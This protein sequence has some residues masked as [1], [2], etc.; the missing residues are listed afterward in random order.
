MSTTIDNRV[1]SLEFDS[2]GFT[3]KIDAAQKKLEQFEETLEFK[4]VEKSGNIFTKL[5][6]TINKGAKD[7]DLSPI[8]KELEKTSSSFNALETIVTG[9]FLKLGAQIEEVGMKLA[10]SL[11]VDQLSTGWSKYEQILTA[12]QTLVAALGESSFDEIN[13]T[14]EKLTWY[15]DETSYNLA[16]MVTNISKFANYGIDLEDSANAM[17][18]I[19]N[20]TAKAGGN[21]NNASH[22]MQGFTKAISMGLMQY[23]T[24]RNWIEN[25]TIA[26]MDFKQQM[27]ETAY[28]MGELQKDAA[29]YYFMY[30]I[31]GGQARYDVTASNMGSSDSLTK[32]KWLTSDVMLE[33][34]AKY[35]AAVNDIYEITKE[36]GLA[37]AEVFDLV[38]KG[39][40]TLDEYSMSA[41]K[42]AQQAKTFS[43][44]IDAL[45]DALSTKWYQIF[46]LMF[47]NYKQSVSLWSEF[48]EYLYEWFVE[49]V[50]AVVDVITEW[51]ETTTKYGVTARDLFVNAIVN[52]ADA[53][54]SIIEPIKNAWAI[55]FNPVTSGDLAEMTEGFYDFTSGLVLTKNQAAKF[56]DVM[57]TVFSVI[58]TVKVVIEAIAKA[59]AKVLYPI[60]K[61][62]VTFIGKIIYKVAK[63]IYKG[64]S[65]LSSFLSI[66]FGLPDFAAEFGDKLLELAEDLDDI[67]IS[68]SSATK[69]IKKTADAA[70]STASSTSA[71]TT[72][73]NELSNAT[74]AETTTS[75]ASANSTSST[76]NSSS[77]T[78]EEDLT[79]YDSD[80]SYVKM[81]KQVKQYKK[82]VTDAK[83]KVQDIKDAVQKAKNEFRGITE[84]TEAATESA[85][86]AT[87]TV[88]DATTA[89]TDATTAVTNATTAVADAQSTVKTTAEEVSKTTETVK[90]A[91][92]AVTTLKDTVD[93]ASK[94]T[95]EEA[96]KATEATETTTE[97]IKEEERQLKHLSLAQLGKN[98]IAAP[99]LIA[100]DLASI[101]DPIEEMLNKTKIG[102]WLVGIL[103]DLQSKWDSLGIVK[104]V[105]A[106]FED[107]IKEGKTTEEAIQTITKAAEDATKAAK[108]TSDTIKHI[109][110][111]TSEDL[112]E[113]P[114]FESDAGIFST[115]AEDFNTMMQEIAGQS[116]E[117]SG[118]FGGFSDSVVSTAE[119]L[120]PKIQE[121]KD[122]FAYLAGEIKDNVIIK[123]E[124]LRDSMSNL[125]G[126]LKEKFNP[127]FDRIADFFVNISE[128]VSKARKEGKSA[129]EAIGNM[130]KEKLLYFW[131]YI[132]SSP[133]LIGKVIRAFEDDTSFRDVL[134]TIFKQIPEILEPYL[135]SAW[136]K[137]KYYIW[138]SY[139]YIKS[140]LPQGAQDFLD[141]LEEVYYEIKNFLELLKDDFDGFFKHP[142]DSIK[143]AFEDVKA[144]GGT[145]K[146][147]FSSKDQQQ[148]VSS[149]AG[150]GGAT[151][152]LGGEK[153]ENGILAWFKGIFETVKTAVLGWLDE[154]WT[155]I[156]D[157]V[158]GW[159]VDV[160]GI[161]VSG[162]FDTIKEAF[163]SAFKGIIDFGVS[164]YK[165]IKGIY[166][167]L[168]TALTA[169]STYFSGKN[170]GADSI[171]FMSDLLF[172]IVERFKKVFEG[173]K[174]LGAMARGELDES[175][176]LA[177]SIHETWELIKGIFTNLYDKFTELLKGKLSFADIFKASALVEVFDDILDAW[178]DFKMKLAL[179]DF[180]SEISDVVGLLADSLGGFGSALSDYGWTFLTTG[181]GIFVLVQ[182]L[183]DL[184]SIK[185]GDLS[186]LVT[187]IKQLSSG[188]LSFISVV[189]FFNTLQTGVAGAFGG[190]SG[191][192]LINFSKGKGVTIGEKSSAGSSITQIGTMLMFLAAAIYIIA[193]AVAV[194]SDAY[195][196]M[197]KNGGDIN[198]VI[199]M[200]DAIIKILMVIASVAVI[201]TSI[202][203]SAN[204][205][206]SSAGIS[207][208]TFKFIDKS[209]ESQF[210]QI[211][212]SLSI[213]LLGIAG[214]IAVLAV[215]IAKLNK[216]QME[217]L[218]TVLMWIGGFILAIMALVTII[219]IATRKKETVQ[220]VNKGDTFKYLTKFVLAFT[221]SLLLV[222]FAIKS[223]TETLAEVV[224][225]SDDPAYVLGIIGSLIWVLLGVMATMIGLA[226]MLKKLDGVSIDKT[227]IA[228]LLVLGNAI[229][230]IL[231]GISTIIEAFKGNNNPL[232]SSIGVILMLITACG[233]LYLMMLGLSKFKK[234][235]MEAARQASTGMLLA[236][237]SLVALAFAIKALVAV[238]ETID[239][240]TLLQTVGIIAAFMLACTLIAMTVPGSNLLAFGAGL[241]LI[242]T[243]LLVLSA[244]VLNFIKVFTY[245]MDI[246]N[247]DFDKIQEALEKFRLLIPQIGAIIADLIVNIIGGVLAGLAAM[248]PMIATNL[249][250]MFVEI[251][252]TLA[253]NLEL[254][255]DA[256]ANL[257][258]AFIRVLEKYVYP[259]VLEAW[260]N[261]MAWAK[262]KWEKFKTWFWNT[263]FGKVLSWIGNLVK[264]T[265]A[266]VCQVLGIKSPSTVFADIGKNLILGLWNGFKGWIK[267]LWDNLKKF[268]SDVIDKI[269]EFFGI[270]DSGDP[271][272]GSKLLELGKNIL[273]GL[274]KGIK[275]KIAALA[276]TVSGIAQ[277]VI[278]TICDIFGI[279]SPSKVTTKIGEYFT[280]GLTNGILNKEDDADEAS[281]S[282]GSSILSSLTGS[283]NGEKAGES[284]MGSFTDGLTSSMGSIDTSS[285]L[286]TSSF[287]LSSSFDSATLS[288]NMEDVLSDNMSG[289]LASSLNEASESDEV[290][291]ASA[292]T[293]STISQ[294]ITDSIDTEP[295]IKPVLDLETIKAQADQMSELLREAAKK[296]LGEAYSKSI[297]ENAN[298][299]YT[300]LMGVIVENQNETRKILNTQFEKVNDNLTTINTGIGNQQIS[301]SFNGTLSSLAKILKPEI[302]RYSKQQSA[303]R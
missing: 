242:A 52:I 283:L 162:A 236:A 277:G 113:V 50:Q 207:G 238:F 272:S 182:A 264:K 12:Q 184:A 173:I 118:I 175:S 208:N 25:S 55:V 45:F 108:E 35:S 20:A 215:V 193:K 221:A 115:F 288:T 170:F 56:R 97:A 134:N 103:D 198:E 189:S 120:A 206:S 234:E 28:A 169:L 32:G 11:T 228:S 297:A 46:Q 7:V 30:D 79:I 122:N 126:F 27:I 158:N 73:A 274:I 37:V 295:V 72:A 246:L 191:S 240:G 248:I 179:A 83:Q 210:S 139:K 227:S 164:A 64:I 176:E 292:N 101:F 121:L 106:W 14:I 172:S 177:K 130:L 110:Y 257:W 40:I 78:K 226:M 273:E 65:M 285:L 44:A 58:K 220:K 133:R 209:G 151:A 252:N 181:L 174:T 119:N 299:T 153:E 125:Y 67:A 250:Y 200:I 268:A 123:F 137:I 80:S 225:T 163:F 301:I 42:Y 185:M 16:D 21:A 302:D 269:K 15:T 259:K 117:S 230:A 148:G 251:I 235:E 71:L 286:D 36:E 69:E 298:N 26:T 39:Q 22:A 114:L 233:L 276:E 31:K 282:L 86:D 237:L 303:V 143:S 265:I 262:E 61:T 254:I 105:K 284:L 93:S 82:T 147:I 88:T 167:K 33:A 60:F 145:I 197:E 100:K 51:A 81:H 141:K 194:L 171:S 290:K 90:E 149:G 49:P 102:K 124:E 258:H 57:V 150:V 204:A 84:E 154:I 201:V 160:F 70:K 231:L 155:T 188:L 76:T 244:A 109:D 131:N 138:Y 85:T 229:R 99:Y 54:N 213:F 261:F 24:W 111:A 48:A 4:D 296:G 222:I 94:K 266:K 135:K 218:E 159:F 199:A 217:T 214:A 203:N 66:A 255:V 241:L 211:L 245:L 107:L 95:T 187:I 96:E 267:N 280:Q 128:N 152:N 271:E 2:S 104:N 183:G 140:L 112:A 165:K 300:Q 289:T 13:D 216:D 270:G 87:T 256:L 166:K 287:D 132:E 195:V 142:I 168:K 98:I 5:F 63:A 260:D 202:V 239:L 38:D 232:E 219:A 3:N 59:L 136:E 291:E 77:T 53:I 247:N 223:L 17:M 279:A 75:T 8:N 9:V 224:T 186:K 144:F 34:L 243:S 74:T 6:D 157:T 278:D 192:S 275:D 190:K 146:G 29:G 205:K 47:G 18:G 178:A 116:E 156:K 127:Y 41:F 263:P 212:K 19:A 249:I 129:I 161:D 293:G 91:T 43:E 10:K 281:S 23:D 68:A 1:V 294:Q 92:T 180:V 253:D 62:V 89:V 196:Y